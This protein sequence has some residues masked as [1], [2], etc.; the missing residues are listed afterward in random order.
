MT[1]FDGG[2]VLWRIGT[3]LFRLLVTLQQISGEYI[4][5]VVSLHC[6]D[7]NYSC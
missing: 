5:T 1:K 4:S 7:S 6:T 2:S 3:G